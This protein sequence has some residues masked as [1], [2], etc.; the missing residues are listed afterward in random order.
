M[1]PTS[2]QPERFMPASAWWVLGLSFGLSV[3]LGV[4]LW[5][6]YRTFLLHVH[7]TLRSPDIVHP[8]DETPHSPEDCVDA[9]M[10]WAAECHGIKSLCDMYASYVMELCL[11]AGEHEAYCEEVQSQAVL[12]T[13]GA[14]E[15]RLRGT[16]RNI[17]SESC[18]AAYTTI[19]DYC[20]FILRRR[21]RP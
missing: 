5:T 9:T 8:W 20:T 11:N 19:D 14:E 21:D 12:R 6:Q 3:I 4:V 16:R 13:F 1:Q 15:C 17:D 7:E 18:A 2:E 10:A